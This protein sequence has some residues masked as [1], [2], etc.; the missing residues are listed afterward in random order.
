MSASLRV[1]PLVAFIALLLSIVLVGPVTASPANAATRREKV[2][3][4][5]AVA[6]NQ[7]G[8]PYRYGAAGPNAF[9]CS[10][11]LYYSYKVK[12]G[13]GAFPRTSGAQA[14]FAHGIRRRDMRPGDLMFFQSNGRVY[15]TAIFVG[16]KDGRRLLLH[17]P[18]TGSRVHITTVWTD[19]WFGRT[20]RF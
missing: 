19:N 6:K 1:R 13:F 18:R 20:L 8:D 5:L 2:A 14:R 11:L 7:I 12:S 17:S 15:H 16:W 4:A 10:G 3:H 9:D